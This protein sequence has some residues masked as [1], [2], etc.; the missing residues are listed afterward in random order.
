MPGIARAARRDKRGAR[1]STPGLTATALGRSLSRGWRVRLNALP[2]CRTGP[3]LLIWQ[4]L[5]RLVRCGALI[6]ASPADER[7]NKRRT[8]RG[9]VGGDKGL[10]EESRAL[11]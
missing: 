9:T 4:L 2:L 3:S 5:L 10:S 1:V 6:R 7:P 8:T 11:E